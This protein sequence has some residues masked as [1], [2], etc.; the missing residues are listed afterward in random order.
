[1]SSPLTAEIEAL[2]AAYERAN[3]PKDEE[4]AAE[5]AA[6]R[7]N[8]D[9]LAALLRLIAGLRDAGMDHDEVAQTMSLAVGGAFA[10]FCLHINHQPSD[11]WEEMNSLVDDI[12]DVAS[13]HLK[14]AK[15]LLSGRLN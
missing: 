1:M 6:M 9:V 8:L 10:M 2:I 12:F 13:D 3:A 5:R 15:P 14:S 4:T 11:A 7:G